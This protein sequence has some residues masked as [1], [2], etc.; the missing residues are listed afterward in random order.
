[1]EKG[2]I[3]FKLNESLVNR[4]QNPA[5]INYLRQKVLV[6]SLKSR[7]RVFETKVFIESTQEYV[8]TYSKHRYMKY[9]KSDE[10]E[11]FKTEYCDIIKAII[12]E[13]RQYDVVKHICVND[14]AY[15]ILHSL[16]QK[17]GVKQELHTDY[18][19]AGILNGIV[20][21]LLFINS[22]LF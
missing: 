8:T 5:F 11:K 2:L 21:R 6:K 10:L 18:R 19:P 16:A 15:T 4:I 1:M 13:L 20:F 22:W 3:S 9:F 17:N 7:H 14:I 12:Y